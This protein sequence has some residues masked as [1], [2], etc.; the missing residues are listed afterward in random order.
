[1]FTIG[2]YEDLIPK[3]PTP[4]NIYIFSKII[5]FQNNRS[6]IISIQKT[7]QVIKKNRKLRNLLIRQFIIKI[8]IRMKETITTTMS[9]PF[10]NLIFI[11]F[12]I[13]LKII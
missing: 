4:D 3:D 7:I 2:E 8:I 1:M 12:I 11:R 5:Y 10:L 6:I 13:F 9:L